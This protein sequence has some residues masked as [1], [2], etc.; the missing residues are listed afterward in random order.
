VNRL[1]PARSDKRGGEKDAANASGRNKRD[2]DRSDVTH[3]VLLFAVFYGALSGELSRS[4]A[5]A[6]WWIAGA[7]RTRAQIDIQ[8][9]AASA[10]KATMIAIYAIVAFERKNSQ[11]AYVCGD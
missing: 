3:G 9:F 4:S 7:F 5:P 10:N 11:E 1:T 8:A 2:D 6:G